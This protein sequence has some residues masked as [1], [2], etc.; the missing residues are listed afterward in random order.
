MIYSMYFDGLYTV[1]KIPTYYR[2]YLNDDWCRRVGY[3]LNN[4][5]DS[6][7][8]AR[9]YAKY[10]GMDVNLQQLVVDLIKSSEDSSFV[11]IITRKQEDAFNKFIA[12]NSLKDYIV[13]T[14]P[15]FVTNAN[16]PSN[17]RNLKLVVLASKEHF[18]RDMFND[19]E[20]EHEY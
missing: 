9:T 17:G 8:N 5:P 20:V 11:F 3:D 14:M 12:K 18:W 15:N 13:Y 6:L 10:A 1:Y 7:K 19:E 2:D 4:I 16:H